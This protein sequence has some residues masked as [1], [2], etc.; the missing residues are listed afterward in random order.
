MAE[1]TINARIQCKIDT[2][3]NW[4]TNNPVLLVGELGVESD[5]KLI[6]V[7]DGTTSWTSLPYLQY[8]PLAGGQLT[9][10]LKISNGYD[11]GIQ[12]S[13]GNNLLYMSSDYVLNIRNEAYEDINI[14][15][16]GETKI[17]G[18]QITSD[19]NVIGRSFS[20]NDKSV[21][22][23]SDIPKTLNNKTLVANGNTTIYGTDI[24]LS[25]DN[26]GNLTDAINGKADTSDIPT[27]LSQLSEDTTHRVV[28]D[29]EKA[30][31]NAKSNFDGNYNSLTNKPTIPTKTSQLTNDSGFIN[32]DVNNLTNYLRLTGGNLTGYVT[33]T[34]SFTILNSSGSASLGSI[35][36]FA[37]NYVGIDAT[38]SIVL[39]KNSYTKTWFITIDDDGNLIFQY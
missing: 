32:K 2:A 9:G 28:T 4:K 17:G 18:S 21:A 3:E 39:G 35:G 25:S 10:A 31:W 27:A 23:T 6:K 38:N 34:K 30:T 29:T 36:A 1:K 12:D 20:Y 19:I 37:N 22:V 7:G 8:L 15:S 11:K 16:L 14:R 13:E 24:T 26:A 33:T 5:T